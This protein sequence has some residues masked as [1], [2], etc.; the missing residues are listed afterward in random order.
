MPWVF[1]PRAGVRAAPL[2]IAVFETDVTPPIGAALCDG[3]VMPAKEIVDPLSARGIILFTNEKPIVIVALDWVGIGNSGHTAFR[4]AIANAAGTTRDRVCVH[5]LHQHDAPGCDFEADEFL[6][7]YKLGG[8]LFDPVFARK[9]IDRIA[10]AVEKAAKQPQTVTHIGVG[11]AKVVEVASN[12]RVMGPDGKVKYVRYSATKDPKIRAEPEGLI[13]PYVQALAFYNGEKPIS[14]ITYYATHPQSYYGKGGVSC[15]FPGLARN[16]CE[17]DAS[18][19]AT[20]TS[21][22]PAATSPPASTTT[23]RS[24]TAWSSPNASP[25]G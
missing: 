14:V 23:A 20:S 16:R 5:C 11:K 4:E 3:L 7:P 25:R 12:R 22:A 18:G 17:R 9:A 24:K 6:V 13:D 10:K 2:K 1:S 19:H 15:D 8:K 21:T